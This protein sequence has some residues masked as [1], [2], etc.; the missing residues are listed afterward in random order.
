MVSRSSWDVGI[1]GATCGQ[2]EASRRG[3]LGDASSDP[4]MERPSNGSGGAGGMA[5]QPHGFAGR[6]QPGFD[7]RTDGNPLHVTTEGIRQKMVA[8]VSTVEADLISEETAAD[9]EAQRRDGH[10]II[11]CLLR[12]RNS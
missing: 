7:L 8:L 6:P 4:G 11:L 3:V 9:P 5:D 2:P 12:S 1:F 10:R